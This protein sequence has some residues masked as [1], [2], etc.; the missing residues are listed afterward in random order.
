MTEPESL[1]VEAGGLRVH[2][3]A[4]GEEGRPV[5]F[6]LHGMRASGGRRFS[7]LHTLSVADDALQH[8]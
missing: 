5:L 6:L 4:W 3:S 7:A 2:V 1:F 8:N